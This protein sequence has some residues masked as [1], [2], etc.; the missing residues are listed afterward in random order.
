MACDLIW[1]EII[2]Y[3]ANVQAQC[4]ELSTKAEA[5]R[6][7]ISQAIDTPEVITPEF[8]DTVH[9]AQENVE[10]D[11]K[12]NIGVEDG[13]MAAVQKATAAYLKADKT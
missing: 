12:V 7:S 10:K 8:L 1:Q 2:Q 3:V 5:L 9:T 6:F 11:L 4:A 13:L